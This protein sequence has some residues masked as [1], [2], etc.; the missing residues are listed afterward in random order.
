[1][2]PHLLVFCIIFLFSLPSIFASKNLVRAQSFDKS[3]DLCIPSIDSYEA[4]SVTVTDINDLARF[5][6]PEQH[7]VC[8]KSETG[9][10]IMRKPIQLRA[11]LIIKP[12]PLQKIDLMIILNPSYIPSRH[13]EAMFTVLDYPVRFQELQFTSQSFVNISIQSNEASFLEIRDCLFNGFTN[14]APLLVKSKYSV[15][16]RTQF[17]ACDGAV[18][19]IRPRNADGVACFTEI[20]FSDMLSGHEPVTIEA[21]SLFRVIVRDFE[22]DSYNNIAYRNPARRSHISIQNSLG[23]KN[24]EE[25]TLAFPSYNFTAKNT[26]SSSKLEVLPAAKA[27]TVSIMSTTGYRIKLSRFIVGIYILILIGI[28]TK[29]NK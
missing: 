24:H 3:F 12:H 7:V 29:I 18:K 25:N 8:L 5:E 15:I 6:G 23:I 1:M 11:P 9:T 20:A 14:Q 26:V 17:S 16:E 19:Y 27:R 21:S 13:S 4:C 22:T 10:L 28:A 2:K